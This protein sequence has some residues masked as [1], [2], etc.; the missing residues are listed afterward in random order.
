MTPPKQRDLEALGPDE[1]MRLLEEY[2]ARVGRLAIADPRPIILP[3]N[4]AVDRGDIVFRTAPGTKL[5]AALKDTFVAFEVDDV[6]AEWTTGWSVLVR[7]QAG[8]VSD[9]D[10]MR[11]LSQLNLYA[12]ASGKKDHF[13][14]ISNAII[15]G[16]RFV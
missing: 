9:P 8:E 4:Y 2:P 6:T 14:R 10:E 12:W 13:V 5:D 1:C 7:G 3:V 16:R 15:S 11:R